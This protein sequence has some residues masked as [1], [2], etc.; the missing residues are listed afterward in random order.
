MKRLLGNKDSISGLFI[1]LFA[2]WAFRSTG[3]FAQS[4]ISSY[5]NPAIAPRVTLVIVIGLAALIMLDGLRQ[6][7]VGAAESTVGKKKGL[8][9]LPEPLT[10]ALILVYVIVLKPVGY[11][12]ATS[13]YLCLQMFILSCFDRKKIWQFLIISC[14]ISP[15]LFY[16]FRAFFNVLL[17]A[18]ILG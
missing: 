2:I 4:S 14:L 9:S 16:G 1:L 15:L 13:V 7:D 3:E 12:I 5:G 11:V 6:T 17:P 18:G 10:F 8:E